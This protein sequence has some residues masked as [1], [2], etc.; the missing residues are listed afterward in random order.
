MPA[1]RRPGAA[2]VRSDDRFRAGVQ[3]ARVAVSADHGPTQAARA[4]HAGPAESSAA[5][6]RGAADHPACRG[7]RGTSA[8][9]SKRPHYSEPVRLRLE[10]GSLLPATSFLTAQR[11]RRLLI[12]EAAEKMNEL[13]VLVAPATPVVA[14]AQDAATVT[15]RAEHELRPALLACVLGPTELACPIVS[16]PIGSHDGLPYGMQVIGLRARSHCCCRW[17]AHARSAGRGASA[18]PRSSRSGPYRS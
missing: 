7:G 11:A 12:E 10:A 6:A 9:S 1:L 8:G 15:I 5:C 17:P 2:I 13:D 3:L 18:C 4:T 14:P 16:V